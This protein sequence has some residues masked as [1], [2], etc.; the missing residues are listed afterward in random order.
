MSQG[1]LI[2]APMPAR[3]VLAWIA[4]WNARGRELNTLGREPLEVSPPDERKRSHAH[5]KAPA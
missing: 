3:E 4:S 5:D 2:D 1:F